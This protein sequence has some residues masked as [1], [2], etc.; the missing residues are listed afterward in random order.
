MIEKKNILALEKND[1]KSLSIRLSLALDAGESGVWDWD[2]ESNTIIWDDKLFEIYGLEK[3]VPMPYNMWLNSVLDEDKT[4]AEYSLN[5]AILNK[6]K[7]IFEFRIMKP[8]NSIIYI[9]A[10]A[11]VLC[12][13]EGKVIHLIGINRDITEKRLL[14][15]NLKKSYE[16]IYKLTENIPGMIYQYRLYPDGSSRFPYSSKGIENIFEISSKD[17][18]NDA[19]LSFNRICKEDLKILESSIYESAQTMKEWNLEYRVN[20]PKK[21]LR[22][23]HGKA[24]PEKLDDGSVLWHGIINDITEQV[25]YKEKLLFQAKQL[26]QKKQDLETIIQETPHPMILHKEGRKILMLNQAWVNSSGFSL[27]DTPTIDSW[28]EHTYDDEETI[29][30]VR[31]HIDS[32]YE[33]TEKVDEGEFTFLNKDRKFVTWQISSAPL[34]LI[35]GKR[36]IITSAMDIT[37]L[38]EKER[39]IFEQSKMAAM[40]EMIGNI[41]HQWRQPLSIIST[42]STGAKLQKEMDCLSDDELISSLNTINTSAQYLS[43][44][45]EDFKNFFTPSNNK[46]SEFNILDAFSKTLT[47]IKAQFVSR[48]IKIIQNIE[49]FKISS[50]E[51]E[52]IQVL[53]NILNNARDALFLKEKERKLIFIN[54]YIKNDTFYIVIKDNA[55][56][57]DESIINR[58]F[59]P[60]FTTKHKSQGTG[61]GL[62]MSKEIIEKHLNGNLFISNETYTFENIEY[63]GAKFTI[64]I[65]NMKI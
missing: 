8:D 23:I 37:E 25:S 42:A 59:E 28:L 22:W 51:N 63:I 3:I 7:H 53:I 33:I 50:I 36:T 6:T 15:I 45:I 2:L 64:E 62:Y 47:L 27:E 56:G 11:D 65:S 54:T 12:D 4:A 10:G 31:K 38:K 57:I 46:I 49:E 52:L 30:N 20:L 24:K 61:I 58:I 26:E 48:D 44:T 35:D 18:V 39:I 16:T 19:T 40:G 1:L 29:F 14:E 43:S 9:Q 5:Q 13:D 34:G 60:Y 17:V 21:G 32:L 41:A 55:G